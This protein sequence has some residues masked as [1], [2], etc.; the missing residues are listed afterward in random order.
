MRSSKFKHYQICFRS[1]DA[2]LQLSREITYED[3]TNLS[4]NHGIRS[5]TT[6]LAALDCVVV[7]KP[8][9]KLDCQLNLVFFCHEES[10][11]VERET[12]L[13]VGRNS[14]IVGYDDFFAIFCSSKGIAAVYTVGKDMTVS[15]L[16]DY[17][18]ESRS[19]IWQ[20]DIFVRIYKDNFLV[21]KLPDNQTNKSTKVLGLTSGNLSDF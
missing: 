1:F 8:L 16:L 7:K 20:S 12:E 21:Q 4:Q 13:V 15:R 17:S 2:D 5:Q 10:L 19:I 14:K 3:K 9:N 18:E 6:I 11:C